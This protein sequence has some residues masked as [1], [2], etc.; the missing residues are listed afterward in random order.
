MADQK[1]AKTL[2]ARSEIE[3][4]NTWRLE[5]V[6]YT[7]EEWEKEFQAVKELLPKLTEFKGKL[8]DSADALLATLQYED[9]VSM[10]LGNYIHML[11]CVMT[12][13]RQ[14]LP[15]KHLM[16]VQQTCTLK[17]QAVWHISFLRF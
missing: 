11:I 13:I 14:T 6:F 4:L 10:R 15:I 17:H 8:G 5:D 2:P 1:T 9:E 16:I 3:E 12:K 7:D